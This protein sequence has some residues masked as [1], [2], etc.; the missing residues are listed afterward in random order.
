MNRDVPSSFNVFFVMSTPSVGRKR[1]AL[2]PGVT[3]ATAWAS[4]LP[5]EHLP[6]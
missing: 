4:Q 6:R 5:R 2:S 3:H 1:T